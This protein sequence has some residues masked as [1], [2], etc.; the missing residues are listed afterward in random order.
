MVVFVEAA[1][2]GPG[3]RVRRAC[4]LARPGVGGLAVA[5]QPAQGDA[6][7]RLAETRVP[8]ADDAALLM[9]EQRQLVVI[10]GPE[11]SLA[12]AYQMD[13]AHGRRL[14]SLDHWRQDRG[15]A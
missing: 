11:R 3:G 7:E 5:L 13:L 2:D 4:D 15:D 8:A 14:S 10:V 1:I 12:M 9:A 6:V